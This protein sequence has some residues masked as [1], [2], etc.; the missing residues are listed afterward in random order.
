MPEPSPTSSPPDR[1]DSTSAGL[2]VIGPQSSGFASYADAMPRLI[3]LNGPPAVGKSTISAMYTDR[4][5]GVL[6]LDVDVLRCL[7]GGW[8]ERLT[9]TG[10]LTRSMALAMAATHLRAG[11]DVVL[12]QYLGRLSEIERFERIA[13]EADSR[14]IEIVLLDS[15]QA[16]LE[17]FAQR[18]AAPLPPVVRHLQDH[19]E[20]GGGR[21]LIADMYDR[22]IEVATARSAATIISSIA[23]DVEGTY[24]AVCETVTRSE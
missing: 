6:N 2:A 10:R 3:H 24:T 14:F 7:V 8:R 22:L 15:K 11:H 9:E 5:P 13:A 18:G 21:Q 23:G 20:R 1:A 16:S 19:V 12:P 17:R 4:H